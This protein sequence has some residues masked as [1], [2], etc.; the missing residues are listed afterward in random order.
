M[1]KLTLIPVLILNSFL[2][3]QQKIE[4][5]IK[6][7][8]EFEKSYVFKFKNLET[9]KVDYFFSY[10]KDTCNSGSK[11]NKGGKYAIV[12][13]KLTVPHQNDGNTYSMEVDNFILPPNHKLYYS[14]NVK[15]VYVCK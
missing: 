4:I 10:K 14:D 15:G 5:K 11:I 7:V 6:K 12:M 13:S 8:I 1:K 9:R 3:S 2:Y